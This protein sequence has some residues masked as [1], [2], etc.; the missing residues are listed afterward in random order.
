MLE[1][2][3]I[4]NQGGVLSAG[5]INLILDLAILIVPIWAIWKLQMAL[6]RKL[7]IAAIFG[8]GIAYVLAL[9]LSSE[10]FNARYDS[11]AANSLFHLIYST[12]AICVVGVVYRI[13]LLTEQNVTNASAKVGLLT[14]VKDSEPRQQDLI[15][16]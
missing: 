9:H 11:K 2:H 5:L 10:H 1:G 6:K 15:S 13:P 4:D 14:Y 3:C 8:V 7:Q 16:C 12:C